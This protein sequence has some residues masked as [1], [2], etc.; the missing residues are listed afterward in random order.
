MLVSHHLRRSLACLAFLLTA[1][2][3]I[4]RPPATVES[5]T[6][7]GVAHDKAQ[8]ALFDT[9]IDRLAERA[10]ARGDRMLDIPAF[11]SCHRRQ[12]GRFKRLAR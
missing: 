11:R 6:V 7:D 3:A 1:C 4:E 12:H 8:R 2:A 10:I 9:A 5:F